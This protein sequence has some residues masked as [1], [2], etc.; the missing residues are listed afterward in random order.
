MKAVQISQYVSGPHELTVTNLPTPTPHPDKYLIKI[1]ACGTNFFDILQIQGKYQ[2]QPP[3]PWLAGMEFAGVVIATPTGTSS[4]SGAVASSIDG[5]I[6][7]RTNHQFK[8]GDRVFG[9]N[10]GAYATHVLAAEQSLFPVPEGWSFADAAGVYVTTPTA[11]GALVTRAKTQ[12]GEWVLVHAGAGGVGLSAVQIAKALGAVVIATAGSERKRQVCLDYGADYVID[13]RNKDWPQQVIALCAKHRT[14]N[15]KAG[16]DVVYDPVGM[17]D[18][19]IKCIAWNGRLLVIGFAGGN[20]EKVALNRV[21]LK[22]ISIVGL[23]WGMYNTKETETVK[24]VWKGIFDLIASGKLK[25]ITYTDK[26]Y[27]GLETIPA[28]LTALG[29]RDTWGKVVVELGENEGEDARSKL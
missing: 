22:N 25:G 28:A 14:G 17:I 3:L 15:G 18:V 20:I 27:K 12:P 5:T 16:V 7:T 6:S 11:Y 26:T 24:E 29:A 19:S 21:L 23:H 10:Q 9:A 4:T 8:V 2:H 1:R 13:Y